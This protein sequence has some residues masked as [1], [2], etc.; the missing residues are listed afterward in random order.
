MSARMS[1]VWP[2]LG[3]LV[4][5]AP[6]LAQSYHT[7]SQIGAFLQGVA[8]DHP[9]ITGFYT[10]GYSEEGRHLW[11]IQIT[12][13]PDIEEDEPEFRYISTMHGNEWVGNEMCLYFIDH[14]TDNYG[15][16]PDLTALVD[17]ID[18]W[19]VPL[20]EPRRLRPRAA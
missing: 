17:E 11:A 1:K 7:Y 4:A 5:A 8:D 12:D 10:L 18:I 9:D 16:D 14:L 19:V 20:D 15:V 6:A 2:A 13:N 3:L